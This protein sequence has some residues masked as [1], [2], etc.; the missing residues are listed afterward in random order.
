MEKLTT[1]ERDVFV[2]AFRYALPRRTFARSIVFDELKKHIDDFETWELKDLRDECKDAWN[3][4][5]VDDCD[6]EE[7]DDF[8]R[9]LDKV[10][11]GRCH[12][13]RDN[14]KRDESD[15]QGVQ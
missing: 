8:A 12:F 7:M 9:F 14:V 1:Q 4:D 11:K 2:F 13:E 15:G 5:H 3:R 10:V 6:R